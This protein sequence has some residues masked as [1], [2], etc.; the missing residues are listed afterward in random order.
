MNYPFLYQKIHQLDLKLLN[1]SILF[2]EVAHTVWEDWVLKEIKSDIIDSFLKTHIP[3]LKIFNNK[4]Y[5]SEGI[6]SNFHIDRFYSHHLL[7]RVLIPL[8]DHFEYEWIFNEKKVVYRPVA[9]EAIL[10]NNMLPHRFV[11]EKN[12]VRQVVYLD[13]F[14]P[15]V[16]AIIPTLKGNYSFEN[17]L[18]AKE[19]S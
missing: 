13:L 6:N 9:G 17:G 8:Q 5:L 18:L 11:S 2:Q 10:F 12:E 16:E 1:E 3:H 7:H 14:D 19:F 15:L 4:I